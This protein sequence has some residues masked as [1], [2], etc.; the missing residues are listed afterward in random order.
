MT[1]EL[2][3]T[4]ITGS[5]TVIHFII[6]ALIRLRKWRTIRIIKTLY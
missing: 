1:L 3:L 2:R 6:I 4:H 5:K